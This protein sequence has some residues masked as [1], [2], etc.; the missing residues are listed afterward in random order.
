MALGLP[1]GGTQSCGGFCHLGLAAGG[2]AGVAEPRRA[3]GG[4]GG[5]VHRGRGWEWP[6]LQSDGGGPVS[7]MGSLPEGRTKQ[8]QEEG[9]EAPCLLL[10]GGMVVT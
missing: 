9:P 6:A 8:E 1:S 2:I 5:C 4:D 7:G 3:P 10:E